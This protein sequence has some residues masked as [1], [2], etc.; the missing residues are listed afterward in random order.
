MFSLFMSYVTGKYSLSKES[1]SPSEETVE[2]DILRMFFN[3]D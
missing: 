3:D 2:I 1:Q